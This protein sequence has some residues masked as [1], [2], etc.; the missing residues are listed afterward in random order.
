MIPLRLLLPL[1]P[2][3][4]N[5]DDADDSLFLCLWSTCMFVFVMLLWVLL[6]VRWLRW[7]VA[8]AAAVATLLRSLEWI[9]Q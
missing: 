8:A 3:Q 6:T 4:N 1:L 5:N 2:V 7:V 9:L